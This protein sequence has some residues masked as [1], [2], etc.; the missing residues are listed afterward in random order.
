MAKKECTP[1]E[2]IKT[3]LVYPK[4]IPIIGAKA[5]P[6][7]GS[8]FTAIHA[9]AQLATPNIDAVERSNQPAIIHNVSAAAIIAKGAF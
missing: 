5:S 6:N 8:I 7:N 1:K 4:I 2:V 9:A 3:P